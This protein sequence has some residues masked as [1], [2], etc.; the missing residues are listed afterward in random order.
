MMVYLMEY[1]YFDGQTNYAPYGIYR[2][3]EAAKAEAEKRAR[4]RLHWN[5][6]DKEEWKW[7]SNGG[8]YQ[9]T[10]FEVKE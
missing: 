6:P 8:T 7:W 10:G 9:I 4:H 1:A 3:V 2:T 5:G